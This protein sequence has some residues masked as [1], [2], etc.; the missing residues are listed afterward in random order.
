[1]ELLHSISTSGNSIPVVA[2]GR[3]SSSG[4]LWCVHRGDGPSDRGEW[5][6]CLLTQSSGQRSDKALARVDVE[7][8]SLNGGI[9]RFRLD[10]SSSVLF[11][12]QN[13]PS[14]PVCGAFTDH[15]CLQTSPPAWRT[16]EC[17]RHT[18]T[19]TEVINFL[20]ALISPQLHVLVISG[21][22]LINNS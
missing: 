6:N 10:G 1:M 19:E 15:W 20:L 21:L 22:V 16:D 13:L 7:G 3:D 2:S 14:L 5:L 9:P 18:E 8:S 4:D 17:V 11:H 12:R